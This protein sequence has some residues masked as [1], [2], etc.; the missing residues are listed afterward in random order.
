MNIKHLKFIH[1]T[2]NAGTSIED[3][4]KNHNI[5]WGRYHEEYKY[6]SLL[7]KKGRKSWH[8]IITN[9]Q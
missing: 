5:L 3:A 1:I 7:N 9:K 6:E 8:N 2:K 4:G